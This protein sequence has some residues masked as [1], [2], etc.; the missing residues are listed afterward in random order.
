[1]QQFTIVPTNS[2]DYYEFEYIEQA[3]KY[4]LSIHNCVRM[5]LVRKSCILQ[6]SKELFFFNLLIC[7]QWYVDCRG[8]RLGN[9]I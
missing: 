2:I 7:S 4:N 8:R 5:F 9:I 1:M 6:G 3:K